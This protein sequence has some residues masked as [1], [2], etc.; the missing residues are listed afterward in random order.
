MKYLSPT[1]KCKI[2]IIEDSPFLLKLYSEEL[3]E[4][5]YMVKGCLDGAQALKM[6]K[7]NSDIDLIILDAKLPR[8]DGREFCKKVKER[9]PSIPV[10]VNSAYDH[11]EDDFKEVGA[12][13]YLVKSSNLTFLKETVKKFL[14]KKQNFALQSAS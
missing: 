10:I 8:M 3:T 9:L 4:E 11:L 5:G 7:M 1:E 12:A 2:L 13:E 6:V 14:K